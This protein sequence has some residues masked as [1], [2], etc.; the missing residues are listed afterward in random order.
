MSSFTQAL[1]SLKIQ[2]RTW[3]ITGVAGF[4]GS[5]LLEALLGLGQNVT[6]LD[7]F[8]T[9]SRAN[10][11]EVKSRLPEAA[12]EKFRF[13]EGSISDPALCREA[14]RGVDYVLHEAGF[15]SVPLSLEDPAACNRTNVEGFVNMLAAARDAGVRRFVYASSSAVYGD[16]TAM[17]KVE[18][19]IGRPLSPYGASKWINEI[20]ARHLP[21][22]SRIRPGR[23]PLFQHL[24]PAPESR[25][26]LCGGRSEM[27]RQSWKK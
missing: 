3:L 22:G 10:M 25:G 21:A 14:A 19:R 23:P 9:G 8:S 6:G 7:D 4:I 2:P 5:H 13:I 1:D 20:Y 27:D 12:W 15:V 17:P 18:A 24:R 26:R 16:D 11:D